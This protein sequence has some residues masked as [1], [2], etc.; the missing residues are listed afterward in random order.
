MRAAQRRLDDFAAHF[1][2]RGGSRQQHHAFVAADPAVRLYAAGRRSTGLRQPVH[3]EDL[4]VAA[5]AAAASPAAVN[6][7]Y[8][9]P[10]N[11]TLAY[12]EMVGRIFDGLGRPRRTISVP[13]LLWRAGFALAKPLFPEANVA[14][15]IRMMKDMTFDSAPAVRDLGWKPRG[16]NPVFR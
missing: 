12:R 1:D 4:A 8:A 10:G 16:F 7:T 9:L 3:A 5:I 6:N 2:L 15:G 13:S 11:E 14:M